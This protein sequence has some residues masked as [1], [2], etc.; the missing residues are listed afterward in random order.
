MEYWDLYDRDRIKTGK[1]HRRGDPVPAGYYRMVIHVCIFN[2]RGQMLIQQRQPFKKGWPDQWDVTVGGSAV[3]GEDSRQAAERETLEEI[4]LKLDLS[5]KRPK[6]TINFGE[7]FDDIYLVEREVD[8]EALRLQESEVQAVRW[9]SREEILAMID[10]GA[11]IPYAKSF[12]ELL[13]DTRK[14]DG[15]IPGI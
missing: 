6:L 2:A 14:L 15:T 7:G 1:A 9:A 3:A 13:F 8:L 12:I 11:F 10:G 5:D 4:G